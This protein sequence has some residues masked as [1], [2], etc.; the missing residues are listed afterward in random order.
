MVNPN[1]QL[2]ERRVIVQKL[3][4]LIQSETNFLGENLTK[5]QSDAFLG[6]L[7]RLFDIIACQCKIIACSAIGACSSPKTCSGFHK[8]ANV[9][10]AKNIRFGDIF[11]KVGG[12]LTAVGV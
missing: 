6:K 9:I 2:L 4:M 11:Q 12:T 5:K 3:E 7:P 8:S 10:Q 1:L